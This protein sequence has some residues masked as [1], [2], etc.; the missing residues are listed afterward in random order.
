MSLSLRKMIGVFFLGVWSFVLNAKAMEPDSMQERDRRCII[1]FMWVNEASPDFEDQNYIFPEIRPHSCEKTPARYTIDWL[2]LWHKGNPQ[3]PINFWYDRKSVSDE[4]L[5]KTQRLLTERGLDQVVSLRDVH[6]LK[7]VAQYPAAFRN[8]IPLYFRVDL[9]R[10]VVADELTQFMDKSLIV[11]ADLSIAPLVH[12]ALLDHQTTSMLDDYGLVLSKN[13]H[14]SFSECFENGF[15]ILNGGHSLMI[16]AH[17]K[18][19]IEI[20]IARALHALK[21]DES[22]GLCQGYKNIYSHKKNGGN[23]FWGMNQ[24]VYESYFQL[25]KLYFLLKGDY[26]ILIAKEQEKEYKQKGYELLSDTSYIIN[27]ETFSKQNLQSWNAEKFFAL[28]HPYFNG[29]VLKP[30]PYDPISFKGFHFKDLITE[31]YVRLTD[32]MKNQESV[33]WI[34]VNS[35]DPAFNWPSILKDVRQPKSR[36]YHKS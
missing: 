34:L 25:M 20:N 18:A 36:H 31:R 3:C 29:Q 1:N 16:Q 15:F 13:A 12:E 32:L 28:D 30:Y 35:E 11:Y 6:T 10:A 23:V 8:P 21:I 27:G 14:P 9:L 19:I 33:L 2:E 4:A 24:L 7:I 17:R 5:Y 26:R 22:T